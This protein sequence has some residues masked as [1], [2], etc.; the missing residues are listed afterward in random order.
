M[1]TAWYPTTLVFV[2]TALLAQQISLGA[3]APQFL[4]DPAN[5]SRISALRAWVKRSVGDAR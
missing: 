2:F 3:I 1:R 4:F 5:S